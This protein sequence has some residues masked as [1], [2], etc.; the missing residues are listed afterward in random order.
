MYVICFGCFPGSSL[1]ERTLH[2]KRKFIC[3]SNK[4]RETVVGKPPCKCGGMENN[5]ENSAARQAY[6]QMEMEAEC[7][8]ESNAKQSQLVWSVWLR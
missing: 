3:V 5:K 4:K 1:W 6:P 8:G 7:F 2:R